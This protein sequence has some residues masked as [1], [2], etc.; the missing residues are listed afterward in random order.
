M[1]LLG[2]RFPRMMDD[3]GGFSNHQSASLQEIYSKDSDKKN[4]GEDLEKKMEKQVKKQLDKLFSDTE[5]EGKKRGYEKAANEYSAAFRRIEKEFLETKN[6]IE[7][8]KN[9]YERQAYKLIDRLEELEKLK[10]ALENRVNS[11]VAQVSS[12]YNIPVCDV[13]RHMQSGTLLYGEPTSINIFD[14]I[15]SYKEKKMRQAEKKGYAEAKELYETK[16]QKL[17]D[18]LWRLKEKGGSETKILLNQISQIM[19][20]IAEKEMQIA[21]LQI[22]L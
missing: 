1:S 9:E 17:K 20:A 12:R 10:E 16:I 21:E 5:T 18:E 6:L 4:L 14:I 7:S 19:D 22:L 15:F 3:G 11:S 8:Q 13:N 2:R